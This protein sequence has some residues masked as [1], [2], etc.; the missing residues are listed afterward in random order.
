MCA[1]VADTKASLYVVNTDTGE[2]SIY[3]QGGLVYSSQSAAA[4]TAPTSLTGQSPGTLNFRAVYEQSGVFFGSFSLF[5]VC[6]DDTGSRLR[7]LSG[8]MTVVCPPLYYGTYCKDAD[9]VRTETE[10]PC[11]SCH[12]HPL[13]CACHRQARRSRASSTA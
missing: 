4:L 1:D 12:H 10:G 8:P 9:L 11:E 13:V 5:L 6:D 7:Y 3:R 2:A